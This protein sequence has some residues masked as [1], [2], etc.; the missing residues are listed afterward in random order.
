MAGVV[1]KTKASA[2]NEVSFKPNRTFLLAYP[3][4]FPRKCPVSAYILRNCP[5]TGSLSIWNRANGTKIGQLG[6]VHGGAGRSQNSGGPCPQ[7]GLSFFKKSRVVRK[8][9]QFDGPDNEEVFADRACAA[10]ISRTFR[11]IDPSSEGRDAPAY[12]DPVTGMEFVSVRGGTF[13]MGDVFGGGRLHE[14]P[15]HQVRLGDF[16][17]GRHE[18]TFAQSKKFA[19]DVQLKNKEEK[20]LVEMMGIEIMMLPSFQ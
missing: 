3:N 15:P 19:D 1:M 16:K 14:T 7:R 10:G 4:E 11:D 20:I 2:D 6:A 9:P 12:V 17:L 18:V 8:K 13:A 5:H